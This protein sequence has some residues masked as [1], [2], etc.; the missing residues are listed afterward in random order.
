[1]KLDSIIGPIDFTA[2]LLPDDPETG[3]KQA[4]PG[5][6]HKN[7]YGPGLGGA[8]WL[9]QGGKYTFDEVPVDK[10]VAPFM[11]DSAIQPMKPLPVS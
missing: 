11:V 1:M 10:T 4:G 8:Q 5:R 7:V 9:M 3:F 6:K 2:E